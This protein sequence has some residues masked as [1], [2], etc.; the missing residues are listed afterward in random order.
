[1]KDKKG[2]NINNKISKYK[3]YM[4]FLVLIVISILFQFLTKGM[5]F[6][7]PNITKL[8]LQN[9]YILILAIGMLPVILTGNVDLSVGSALAIVSAIA[10]KLIIEMGMNIWISLLI[11]ILIG[12][13]L[14]A[15]HGFWIS[16]IK[17]PAF[18][19]TLSGLLVLRGLTIVIL[20]GKT[21]A[22]FPDVYQFIASGFLPSNLKFLGLSIISWIIILA[23][24]L[25]SIKK[26]KG[27]NDVSK[28]KL[29]KLSVLLYP[30][31]A[32]IIV[33]VL[34]RYHGIPVI[35]VIIGALVILYS[36]ILRNTTLG[37]SIYATG[38]NE[39]ATMLSGINTKK[40]LFLTYLNMGLLAA[41]AGIVFSGRLGASTPT[42]GDGFEL[43]AI[44]AC[45]IGGASANGGVGTISGAIIGALIMG[46]L[47]NG[48][49]IM[50]VGTDWQQAIKGIVL[51]L[52]VAFDMYSRRNED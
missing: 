48:M 45:Y 1:M 44:A 10:G 47:N 3:K 42:A 9:S 6:T 16:K 7:P 21:L 28:S 49:S 8:I 39:E 18:I 40:I 20:D 51:L 12:L 35:L 26:V 17:V 19:A 24:V 22:P 30:V 43:D 11:C 34:D 29:G 27:N 33:Y 4:M 37:R 14:G 52:A 41:I 13:I 25:Y 36:F 23:T 31:I 32:A 15:W 38:S 50:G 2:L 46:I 5:L